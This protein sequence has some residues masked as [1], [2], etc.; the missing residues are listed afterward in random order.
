M[1]RD[2]FPQFEIHILWFAMFLDFYFRKSH[3]KWGGGV[4]NNVTG[5]RGSKII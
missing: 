3:V 5:G 2:F 4:R 1:P